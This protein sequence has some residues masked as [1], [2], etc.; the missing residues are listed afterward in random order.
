MSEFD[1]DWVVSP[2]SCIREWIEEHGETIPVTARRC[3]IDRVTFEDIVN[4]TMPIDD[5]LALRIA[6]GTGTSARFWVNLERNYRDGLAAG[7]KDVSD[8]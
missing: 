2:G 5:H 1:P 6:V 4:G 7:R 3:K 8:P